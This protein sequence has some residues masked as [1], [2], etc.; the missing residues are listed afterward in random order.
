[1]KRG[2][3]LKSKL[4]QYSSNSSTTDATTDSTPTATSS[5]TEK[6]AKLRIEQS[7]AVA[8]RQRRHNE[9]STF[10]GEHPH[11]ASLTIHP[12]GPCLP[13]WTDLVAPANES[14]SS[15]SP[16]TRRPARAA[17]GPPPPPSW[18]RMRPSR[19]QELSSSTRLHSLQQY[20]LLL[21]QQHGVVSSLARICCQHLAALY[22]TT[23]TLDSSSRWIYQMKTLPGHIKQRI[24]YEWSFIGGEEYTIN[25]MRSSEAMVTDTTM[26]LFFQKTEYEELWLEASHL[27]LERLIQ[28]FWKVNPI[29][30]TTTPAAAAAAAAATAT[31]A[32]SVTNLDQLVDDWEDLL[33]E[34]TTTVQDHD[35]NDDPSFDDTLPTFIL[36]M[37][38][39]EEIG[40]WSHIYQV[41]KFLRPDIDNSYRLP[42][43]SS[44]Y[45]LSSPFL[46]RTLVSLNL[47]FMTSPSKSDSSLS[48]VTFAYLMVATLPNLMWLYTAGCFDGGD[49]VQ[50]TRVLSILSHGLR[51]L[52]FWDLC[53]Y[54]WLQ[55]DLLT[56][57]V[58]W[59]RDLLELKTLCLSSSGSSLPGAEHA[60]NQKAIEISRWFKENHLSRISI[61]WVDG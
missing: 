27:S 48:W 39:Q 53:Y 26:D 30:S 18:T 42:G 34:D 40:K 46:G 51:K 50:G 54:D 32:V 17:A 38:E 60:N 28:S 4:R 56:S 52:K 61:I 21:K 22:A 20:R 47:S 33:E 16:S 49:V 43:T 12:D 57:V 2:R 9:T 3:Q 35:D 19:Q 13:P 24:L 1:M 55:L 10:E 58:D 25:G 23:N 14:S 11:Q 5:V 6:I 29:T 15:P 59:R 31:A 45:A 8:N 36:H 7:R 41:M 37:D 44:S